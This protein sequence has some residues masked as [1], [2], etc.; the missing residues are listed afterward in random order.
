[1]NKTR[2]NHV[3]SIART[4]DLTL[5][6]R[7][8]ACLGKHVVESGANIVRI[9]CGESE[10][11]LLGFYRRAMRWVEA[12]HAKHPF[13]AVIAAIGEE[14]SGYRL[15]RRLRGTLLVMDLWD[16]PGLHIQRTFSLRRIYRAIYY[17]RLQKA[18]HTADIVIAGV[19]PDGLDGF[20]SKDA[21][22]IKSENG[23]DVNVFVTKPERG[24]DDVWNGLVGDCRLLYT[25]YLAESRGCLDLLKAVARGREDGRSWSCVL[26]G[27]SNDQERNQLDAFIRERSLGHSC[28]ILDSVDSRRIPSIV[29]ACDIGLSPLHPIENYKWSYPVKT[30]EYLSVGRP[31][32]ASDLP[33]NR[34][35]YRPGF[36][37]LHVPGNVDSLVQSIVKVEESKEIRLT[38]A[39]EGPEF[40]REHAWEVIL[41]K[42]TTRLKQAI[43]RKSAEGRCVL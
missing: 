26:I 14:V 16:V 29:A 21:V 38:A 10:W 12:E 11:S 34:A 24:E 19:L 41:E 23:V 13:D 25:G 1:M 32:V 5:L 37:S 15:Q 17:L 36:G 6:V 28:R 9:P 39:R 18:I 30:L 8:N 33:G 42:L 20:Y 7:E 22:L 31:L 4:S 43:L 2:D 27:P 35:R 40:A 3:C